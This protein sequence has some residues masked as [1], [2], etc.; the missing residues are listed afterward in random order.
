MRRFILV[1]LFVAGGTAIAQSQAVNEPA[2]VKREFRGVWVATVGNID[3][4][5]RRDLSTAQQQQ[6]MRAILDKC[7]ALKLNA[8]VFQVRT[9]A[10]AL[11]ASEFEP[12]SEFLTGTLGKA[13]D[14]LYDPLEFAVREAHARGLELHAWLNPY[15]AKVPASRSPVP[16]NHLVASRP[17]LAKP[18]GKHHWLNPTHPEVQAHSL[19]VFLD[20]VRRYDLDG[21]HMDD[22]FYPYPEKDA[23]EKEI[24]FPDDDTWAEYQKSGGKLSRDDW[25][26]AAVNQFVD[27]L[28]KETKA[29]KP[30]VKVGISPFGIWRPGHPPGIEGFDQY[31]KL[32]ADAKLWFNKGWVDYFTPQLYWPIAREKQSYPKLL[33]WWAEQNSQRRHLWPGNYTGRYPA[34]EIVEQ[35]KV[36]RSQIAEPGNVHFSM[37]SILNNSGGKADALKAIYAEPAL[38]PAMPWLGKKPTVRLNV[39]RTVFAPRQLMVTPESGVFRHIIVRSRVGGKWDVAI[40]PADGAEPVRIPIA[41][42]PDRQLISAVDRIGQET[43]P[44]AVTP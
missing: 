43:E 28:Y 32:Y 27:R 23:N 44:I 21:I 1:C 3:W 30:W 25:R 2:P 26:R 11:Y 9:M 7:V 10:D 24:P 4:P 35:I 8:V 17:D 6:E 15:R 34:D 16:A 37:K 38:V 29:L 19:K 39:L 31:G 13:P 18:Y 20:V 42:M 5:S 12:W 41:G 40:Y 36:T 33:A 14:P 22:Y